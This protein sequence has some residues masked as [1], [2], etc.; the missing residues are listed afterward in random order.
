MEILF[1]ILQ[2]KLEMEKKNTL[3]TIMK[4]NVCMSLITPH[5]MEIN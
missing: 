1:Q 3:F 4:K 5:K 2:I